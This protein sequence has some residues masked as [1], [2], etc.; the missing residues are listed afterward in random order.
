MNFRLILM[1]WA[2]VPLFIFADSK[3]DQLLLKV[4]SRLDG[5]DRSLIVESNIVKKG[6]VRKTQNIKI[7]IYWPENEVLDKMTLIEFIKPKR[8]SGVK[9][10]E[11]FQKKK[12]NIKK[13]ITMPVT[14]KL[15]DI[16]KKKAK[17]DDF[18][19]SDLQ[20]SSKIISNHINTIIQ[21]NETNIKNE[22]I[23][24]SISKKNN[25][26]KLI[27]IDNELFVINKVETF[28]SKNKILKSI[29]CNQF[30]TIDD[31]IIATKIKINDFKKKH[32]VNIEIK[33]FQFTTFS[34]ISIFTPEGN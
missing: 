19:F 12:N 10:W 8:K 28:N 6:K 2:I 32:I 1:I 15:K 17:T 7:S 29:M 20:L 18:D 25:Y 13:W 26:K 34:N 14:G 3:A 11:H 9:Y 22:I 33:N 23:V 30:E 27:Y 24:E 16:S 21:N 4:A 5:M 31:F